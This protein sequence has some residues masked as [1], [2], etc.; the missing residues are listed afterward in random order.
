MYFVNAD[1]PVAVQVKRRECTN[2]SEPISEIREFL[3]AMLL[4][5]FRSGI[6]VS[7]ALRFTHLAKVAASKSVEIG[8][9]DRFDLVDADQ[10]VAL[11]KLTY[12]GEREPWLD[13]IFSNFPRVASEIT[14][15]RSDVVKRQFNP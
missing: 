10:F 4:S 12:K 11:L 13:Y 8:L 1:E 14:A 9:T 3:G 7:T 6:F 15:G 5:G 2:A